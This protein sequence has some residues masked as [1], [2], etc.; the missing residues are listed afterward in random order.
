MFL[1]PHY[2]TLDGKRQAHW[3][4]VESVR[5]QRGSWQRVV[6]YLGGLDEGDRLGV[7]QVAD[8]KSTAANNRRCSTTT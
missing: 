2:R 7:Q 5:T 3:S 8:L 6:A 1:R 4:L